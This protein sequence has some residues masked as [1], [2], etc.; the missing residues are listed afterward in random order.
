MDLHL[1][2]QRSLGKAD[3][4][5]HASISILNRPIRECQSCILAHGWQVGS[6]NARVVH[7]FRWHSANI[8]MVEISHLSLLLLVSG[9]R[10]TVRQRGGEMGIEPSRIK[11]FHW[12]FSDPEMSALPVWSVTDSA[13]KMFTEK[14]ACL[15]ARKAQFFLMKLDTV[16]LKCNSMLAYFCLQLKL[17]GLL[18]YQEGLCT[19]D[20][21][22]LFGQFY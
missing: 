14:T 8:C 15:P 11:S 13:G 21:S 5:L 19:V 4:S 9:H 1:L 20:F 12:K 7:S 22:G 17:E 16:A 6:C 10:F 3:A 18:L 2:L